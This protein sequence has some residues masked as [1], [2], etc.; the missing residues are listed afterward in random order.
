MWETRETR[1]ISGL[2]VVVVLLVLPVVVVLLVLLVVWGLLEVRVKREI[3]MDLLVH[4]VLPVL[5][6]I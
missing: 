4:R 6:A 1:A 3:Q 5:T 2:L